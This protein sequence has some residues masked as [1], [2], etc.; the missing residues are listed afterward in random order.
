[1]GETKYVR[2]G[3]N[4]VAVKTEDGYLQV[5]FDGL[6]DEGNSS[7]IPLLADAVFEGVAID[8]L[9]F[10][11]IYIYVHSDVGSAVDGLSAMLSS[12][13]ANFDS[14]DEYT[15]AAGTGKVFSIQPGAQY[16]KIEY[17]NGPIDQT[18][19]RLQVILKRSAGK[20]SSHRL[21][22]AIVDDDDTELVKAILSAKANGGGY[23]NI[24]A[25]KSNNLRVT[26]AE[27]GLAVAKGDVV[28]HTFTH[29]FGNAPDFDT[30]DGQVTIWDGA[31]DAGIDEMQYIYSTTAAIDSISSSSAADTQLLEI[32]GLDANWEWLVQTKALNGQNRVALDTPL[33]R[34]FRKKNINSVDL[35][36]AAY[37]YENT[38]IALG[39]PTD[40][41]KIRSVIQVG[42]NQTTM[43]LL[44]IP[45]AGIGYMRDWYASIAG[46]NKASAYVIE[47]Y[48]RPFGQVFQLKHKS[49]LNETG[50]SYIQHKYEEPEVFVAKTDLEMRA[51]AT[52][53]GVTA[54]SIS[55]GFDVVIVDN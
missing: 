17:T 50:T 53:V 3:T 23:T 38:A 44:T 10:A 15:I 55:A 4:A 5:G 8:T 11:Y 49:A 35:A 18:V 52:A 30:G 34:V 43:A 54:A 46:A 7:N 24:T 9:D 47:L 21:Q 19:F 36:G 42:H 41:T 27:S 31:D 25:T 6:L 26:D 2:I 40:T 22:D 14:T 32:V 20:P 16:F 33:I 29:K 28:G 51:G 39:I 48:A 1:M 45:A 37:C 13:G 12:D